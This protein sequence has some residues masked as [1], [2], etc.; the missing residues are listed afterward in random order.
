MCMDRDVVVSSCNTW[1]RETGKKTR[2]EGMIRGL[3]LDLD[4]RRALAPAL[5]QLVGIG[6]CGSIVLP[7]FLH[8]SAVSEPGAPWDDGLM[9]K[10]KIIQENGDPG[11]VRTS[12]GIWEQRLR[13]GA[14]ETLG[15][16]MWDVEQRVATGAT[17]LWWIS[18]KSEVL[19]WKFSWAGLELKKRPLILS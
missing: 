19:A 4:A 7:G 17:K 5:W 10:G 1:V 2:G 16:G 11:M 18:W 13:R 6:V 14:G 9:Q 15:C 3:W 8:P 12:S